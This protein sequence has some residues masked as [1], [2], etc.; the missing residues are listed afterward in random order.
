MRVDLTVHI[1]AGAL[2][3]LSGFVALSTAKGGTLHRKV[4]RVFVYSMVTMALVGAAMALVR[5]KAPEGNV[6][7]GLLT[8]Y[9]VITSLITVR[10]PKTG[11]RRLEIG[12]MVVVMA[13]SIVLVTFGV[14]AVSSPTGKL[15]GF[16]AA[17]FFVFGSLALL[18]AI[19]DVRLMRLGGVQML[20]GA[21][22]LARHLWRMTLALAI[23]AFSFFL[24]QARVIPKPFRIYPLLAVP[25][26]IVLLSMAY[27]LWRVRVRRKS[28][29]VGVAVGAEAVT[30]ARE[31][32][33]STR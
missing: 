26:V 4:G 24:G 12:L 20:R 3:I 8:T 14:M 29:R 21:P 7:I 5:G 30:T 25:P 27:W 19:G 17:P 32:L 16:P 9:L 15:G 2:G 1:V 22:R 11:V 31:A 28:V 18:A 23:A 10:P 33:A 6:P 13:I